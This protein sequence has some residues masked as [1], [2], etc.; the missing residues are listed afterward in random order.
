MTLTFDTFARTF[1]VLHGTVPLYIRRER[2][3][4]RSRKH[5]T[6]DC[7]APVHYGTKYVNVFLTGTVCV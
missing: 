3:L 5:R 6:N 1:N 7:V 2:K 4:K